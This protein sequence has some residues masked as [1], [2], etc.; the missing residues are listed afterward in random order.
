MN[1]P[2]TAP[3]PSE[4]IEHDLVRRARALVPALRERAGAAEAARRLSDSTIEDFHAAGLFRILQPKRVG[5]FELDYGF[6][7]DVGAEIGRGCGSSAWVLIVLASH[8]W[9][10]GMYPAEAQDEVWSASPDTLVA[11]GF[12]AE[13]SKVV[14]VDGG[15]RVTGLWKY[16]SGVLHCDWIMLGAP[17]IRDGK[18]AEPRLLLLPKS[19]YRIHDTWYAAGLRG[20]GSHDV[21]VDDAFVPEHRALRLAALKGEPTPGSSLNPGHLYRLPLYA[22]FPYNIFAPAV[23]MARGALDSYVERIRALTAKTSG[24]RVAEFQ[25]VQLRVAEAAAEIDCAEYIAKRD[26]KEFNDRARAGLPITMEQR[27]RYRRDV[28]YASTLCMRAVDRLLATAGAHGLAED[29]VEQ[30]A[31]RDVHAV[32]QQIALMW[33]VNAVAFGRVA[34]GLDV[35]DPR[36]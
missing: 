16:A 29:S 2:A 35:G 33:D 12:T 25:S 20:T 19:D 5:G 28:S 27:V 21:S 14:P 31:F 17:V 3:K 7:V 13:H 9:I 11:S 6:Q 36:L 23:G 18:P 1:A 4:G 8:H 22:V 34:L 10:L 15:Y 24:A 26:A 30:R 32:N